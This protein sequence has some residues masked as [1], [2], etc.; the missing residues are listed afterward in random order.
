MAVY[1]SLYLVVVINGMDF[2]PFHNTYAFL[3]TTLI[4]LYLLATIPSFHGYYMKA[5]TR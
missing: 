4:L 2:I 5:D 3:K 1:G